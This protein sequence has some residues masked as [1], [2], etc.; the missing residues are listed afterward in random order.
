MKEKRVFHTELAYVFGIVFIALG[1]ALM[2]K[3][4]FGVSMVVAPAYLMYR[5]INPVWS[6][7]TF[8]MAEYCLQALLLVVMTLIVRRFRVGYLMSFV[9]AV[10]YGFVL[11]AFMLLASYLPAELLLLRGVWYVLGMIFCAAG[12]SMMFHTYISPEVYELFVKEVSDKFG[13]SITRFKT[14]YDCVSCAVGLAMSF[15]IFGMWQF[16]GVS[17]GTVV[18]ALINGAMIG[19]FSSLYEKIWRFEDALPWRRFFT[20]KDE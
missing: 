13:I 15:L 2:E 14:V 1:V 11:D 8:G 17:W 20:G 3:A 9:T 16:V 19:G 4:D 6:A 10:V 5:W 12:V 7:F 18:C